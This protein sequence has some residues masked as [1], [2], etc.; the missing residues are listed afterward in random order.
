MELSYV[1]ANIHS[2]LAPNRGMVFTLALPSNAFSTWIKM[3]SAED[4]A[5][6]E[7]ESDTEVNN[8]YGPS[9]QST[10]NTT[11]LAKAG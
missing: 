1:N 7:P 5:N 3:M 11:A 2:S 6:S 4:W 10:A 9:D 8:T